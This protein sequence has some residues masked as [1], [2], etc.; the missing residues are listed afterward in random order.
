[1]RRLSDGRFC[2]DE[3]REEYER[4]ESDL[5][6][7]RLLG[8]RKARPAAAPQGS[9]KRRAGP[10]GAVVPMAP[11]LPESLRVADWRRVAGPPLGLLGFQAVLSM[12]ES[13]LRPQVRGFPEARP[14]AWASPVSGR[15]VAVAASFVAPAFVPPDPPA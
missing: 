1:M 12:P 7:A 13:L 2:C 8:A 9:D 15:R 11:L 4:L 6:L 14:A 5:A 10:A 3:H